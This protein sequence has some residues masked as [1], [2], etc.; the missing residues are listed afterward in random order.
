MSKLPHNQTS[1]EFLHQMGELLHASMAS[2]AATSAPQNA[3]RRAMVSF[4]EYLVAARTQQN[5][6]RHEFACLIGTTEAYIHALEQGLVPRRAINSY[7]I[8]RIATVLEDEW[9]ILT[10]I[11]GDVNGSSAHHTVVALLPACSESVDICPSRPAPFTSR[12]HETSRSQ[13]RYRSV[14]TPWVPLVL[15]MVYL[16]DR[17]HN[18]LDRLQPSRLSMGQLASKGT[19]I[20][21]TACCSIALWVGVNTSIQVRRVV[22]PREEIQISTV[23]TNRPPVVMAQ[24]TGATVQQHSLSTLPAVSLE[25]AALVNHTDVS[26][27]TVSV[28]AMAPRTRQEQTPYLVNA[29]ESSVQY[30][31]KQVVPKSKS[32]YR[33]IYTGRST[34]RQ[35]HLMPY[36]A[37]NEEQVALIQF[38]L[39]ETMPTRQHCI[40][41]GRFDLCPI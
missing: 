27:T 35:P 7:L 25:G 24:S 30:T 40:N 14:W 3:E 41:S 26:A 6:S 20:L 31:N 33:I 38:Q 32:T 22:R 10:I 8:E 21:V 9:E 11:L 17:Y 28:I 34:I 2:T 13:R 12:K 15:W 5:L 1:D 18:L 23:G 4:G 37:V 16:I 36:I 19:I 39:Q 29:E